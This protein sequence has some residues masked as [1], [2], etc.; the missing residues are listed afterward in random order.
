MKRRVTMRTMELAMRLFVFLLGAGVIM[1]NVF[2][3]YLSHKIQQREGPSLQEYYRSL[4]YTDEVFL[5]RIGIRPPGPKFSHPIKYP[6]GDTCVPGYARSKVTEMNPKFNTNLPLFVKKGFR[7]WKGMMDDGHDKLPFYLSD[8]DCKKIDQLLDLLP[9]SE[10][11]LLTGG[12]KCR[13]CIVVGS[14][15][16]VSGEN[17]GSTIDKY[18]IVM[19]M[20]EAPVHGYE[21]DI[22]SK[23]TFRFLY[24]ESATSKEVDPDADYIIVPYKTDDLAWLL[25]VVQKEKPEGSFWKEIGETLN[26][27]SSHIHILNPQIARST[28][29]EHVGMINIPT[30]GT[31]S[32]ITAF[33]FCD[34]VDI[35]GFGFR[36]DKLYHYYENKTIEGEFEGLFSYFT[37]IHDFAKE[38]E[39]IK[40]LVRNAVV[41]D[42]THGYED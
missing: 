14:S 26:V 23:T 22:G 19:R 32:I 12:G 11:A 33:H 35:V 2:Y 29:Y 3:S 13:R 21:K 4:N 18:D 28:S 25:A 31:I 40:D 37:L 5:K 24:P 15:G 36:H 1:I 8:Q 16:L 34:M 42:L 9:N 10:P 17:L 27:D 30:I 7:E 38:K 39:Y 20:N 6:E 41:N